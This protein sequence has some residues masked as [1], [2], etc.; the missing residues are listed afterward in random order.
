MSRK[1]TISHPWEWPTVA[2]MD[3]VSVLCIS[4][5]ASYSQQTHCATRR[6]PTSHASSWMTLV[7]DLQHEGVFSVWKWGRGTW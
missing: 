5:K 1:V 2:E 4:N 3:L 7:C 6:P